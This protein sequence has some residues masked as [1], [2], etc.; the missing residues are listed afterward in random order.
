MPESAEAAINEK[1]Y[2]E[3]SPEDQTVEREDKEREA[4]G[5]QINA[6]AQE[7]GKR[8]RRIGPTSASRHNWGK[9]QER[10]LASG[11]R[12]RGQVATKTEVDRRERAR[13]S[14]PVASRPRRDSSATHPSHLRPQL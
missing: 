11:N 13:K 14:R 7:A 3:A 4:A 5:I 8:R 12:P 10:Q 9:R 1:L 2:E 6:S